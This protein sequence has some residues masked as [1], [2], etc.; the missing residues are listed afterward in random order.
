M[1][2]IRTAKQGVWEMVKPVFPFFRWLSIKLGFVTQLPERQRY[3]LGYLRDGITYGEFVNHL[4]TQHFV[5]QRMA[6]IDPD[7]VIGMRRL[8]DS[9]PCYQY[10]VRVFKDGEVRGHYEKTPEDFPFDHLKEIGLQD[11]SEHF[12]TFFGNHLQVGSN[13]EKLDST[14]LLEYH[15]LHL[16]A[17][18]NVNQ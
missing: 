1:R 6:F 13:R 3:H 2:H 15:E 11:R 7:E 17:D 10:H 12:V 14:T 16:E 5:F 4:H 18:I 8:D 9:D